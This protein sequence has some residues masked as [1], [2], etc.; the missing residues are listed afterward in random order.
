MKIFNKIN[1]DCHKKLGSFQINEFSPKLSQGTKQR[2]KVERKKYF[3]KNRENF[4]KLKNYIAILEIDT[5]KLLNRHM[6]IVN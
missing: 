1:L 4:I 3:C 5:P 2:G 6:M